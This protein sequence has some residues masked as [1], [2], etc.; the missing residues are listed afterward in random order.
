MSRTYEKLR[1]QSGLHM[2]A[3]GGDPFDSLPAAIAADV[4][5]RVA[6]GADIAACC[7]ASRAFLAASYACSRVRLRAAAL[8]R[9]RSVALA[10][11][12]GAAPAAPPSERP[13]G[14]PRP[15]S[16]RTSAPS[17]STRPRGGAT[18]TTRRGWRRGSSTRA[19]TSTS[20]PG[21]P[22]WRG[23]TPPPATLSGRWTSPTTG[24]SRAGGRRRRFLS[25]PT[26]V[27]LSYL[28]IFLLL[29]SC[30]LL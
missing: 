6:D 20:R 26:S 16:G 19:A 30:S 23:R 3:D 2:S 21:R 25:S 7:L 17:S 1:R 14:T 10:G 13:P 28:C 12:G 9:R 15:S 8:A 24:R 27:I 4:L 5:G 22:W 18:R 29:V 11:G